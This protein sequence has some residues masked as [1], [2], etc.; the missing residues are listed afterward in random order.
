M[1]LIPK[2]SNSNSYFVLIFYGMI[3]AHFKFDIRRLE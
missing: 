1:N 3:P 2:G